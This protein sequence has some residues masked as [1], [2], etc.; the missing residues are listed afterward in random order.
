MSGSERPPPP[1]APAGK[2]WGGVARRGAAVVKRPDDPIDGEGDGNYTAEEK[3]AY[4]A[5]QAK[6]DAKAERQRELQ[7]EASEA[8]SRAGA[9]PPGRTRSM[10]P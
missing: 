10:G 5:R 2:N 4:A 3:A 6:R 8:I 7:D 1:K 9:K